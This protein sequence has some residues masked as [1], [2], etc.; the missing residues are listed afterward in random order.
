MGADHRDRSQAGGQPVTDALVSATTH[1]M[2]QESS[3][4][5][6]AI[7]LDDSNAAAGTP[8]KGLMQMVD[9]TYQA[10]R[11]KGLVDDI[12]NGY[13]N[14]VSS[15]TYVLKDPKY[16]GRGLVSVYRQAGGYRDGGWIRGKVATVT[17]WSRSWPRTR[18]HGECSCGKGSIGRRCRC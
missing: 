11:D 4:N 12:W 1:R 14:L 9:A 13:S 8:S 2:N 6:K 5:E 3:G 18:I 15:M 10:Y 16:T 7:N 17:T